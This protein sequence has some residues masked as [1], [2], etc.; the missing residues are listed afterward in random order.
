MIKIQDLV[1]NFGLNVKIIQKQTQG[2]SHADSLLQLPFRGNN[3][4]WI[5]GHILSGRD[6]ILELLG[7]PPLLSEQQRARY[8]TG[9]PPLSSSSRS[10][11]PLETLLLLLERSQEII[12]GSLPSLPAEELSREIEV[13]EQKMSVALRIFGLYFHETYHT[14]QT[15]ILRQLAG[16]DDKVI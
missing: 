3:L 5:L 13:G 14:G 9:A 7:E 2:L 4:N 11:I 6:F 8:D 10:A 12:E 15:E 1:D 16:K